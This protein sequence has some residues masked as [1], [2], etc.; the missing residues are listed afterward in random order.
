MVVSGAV[1]S[2]P[3]ELA[4]AS[5]WELLAPAV[6]SRP[7]RGSIAIADSKKLFNRQKPDALAHLERGVL[8]ML[9]TRQIR[10]ASVWQLLEAVCPQAA[11]ARGEYP[12]YDGCDLAL[13]R[14]GAGTD[15]ALA[16]NALG[17][18]MD[19]VGLSLRAMRSE[20]VFV[21]Q[22]NRMVA[23]TRNKS[24]ALFDVTS[25]LLARFLAK[26]SGQPMRIYVDRHGGR[27]RY[28]P[29]LERVFESASFKVLEESDSLSAYRLRR[30]EHEAEIHF[31]VDGERRHLPVALASMLSK[32]VRELFMAMLNGFW[33]GRVPELRGTAGYYTD[34][35]R[36]Y[37][38]I[39]PA[40]RSSGIREE[41]IYR[42][43]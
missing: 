12:W 29:G 23:A 24:T 11:A 14:C 41:L 2:V 5:M 13:P 43:R 28:L 27:R 22:F 20:V 34:G 9:A 32:Y 21:G 18:A 16:G 10:P 26:A 37:R 15:V 38:A 42:S 7:R 4:G 17:V 36:F 6:T 3:E 35:R 25:R 8:A 19:R 31:V 33:V 39:E 1:L 30:R 40:M